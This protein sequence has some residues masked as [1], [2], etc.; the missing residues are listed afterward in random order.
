M[1]TLAFATLSQV[2]LWN[3]ELAG[4][5]SDG[6]W[7]NAHPFNHWEA[8]HGPDVQVVVDPSRIGR[9]FYVSKDN[10]NFTAPDLLSVV[11]GR[12]LVY[13]RLGLVYGQEAASLL[14]DCFD[15][16][17]YDVS[18][19]GPP[20]HD[21]EYW[22]KKRERLKAYDMEI[23]AKVGTDPT[24]GPTELRNDLQAMKRTI[25]IEHAG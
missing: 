16:N 19:R 13:V 25:R 14:E 24:Y 5:I 7:E 1:R 2:L 18:F 8:W 4:Q 17:G 10:Y 9:D 11:G 3:L 12:M 23:V 6:Y 21:G 22:D 15:W 20:E